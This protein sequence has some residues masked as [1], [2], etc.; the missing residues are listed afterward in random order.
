MSSG[1]LNIEFF[2]ATFHTIPLYQQY[3]LLAH[4][5]LNP[6]RQ[7]QRRSIVDRIRRPAHVILPRIRSRFPAT[8]GG[9]LATEGAADFGA[10]GAD[11][12]VGDAAVAA[13]GGEE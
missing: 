11:V 13:G 9:L 10:T 4:I 1:Y 7:R 5:K 3:D 12:D 8:T 2:T 6:L